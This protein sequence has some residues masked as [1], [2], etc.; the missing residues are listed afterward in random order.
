[1]VK[2]R[3]EHQLALAKTKGRTTSEEF[4]KNDQ[5]QCNKTKKWV[6]KDLMMLTKLM[7]EQLGHIESHT[8]DLRPG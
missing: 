5:V 6:E 4:K 1:M 8:R 7:G 2:A 3:H